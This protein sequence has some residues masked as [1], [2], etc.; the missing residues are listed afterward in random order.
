MS[1]LALPRWREQTYPALLLRHGA[2]ALAVCMLALWV[3][4]AAWSN[5]APWGDHVE[6]FG[7]AH[8][9]EWGYHKHPPLPT[10]ML[11]ATIALAGPSADWPYALAAVCGC[12]TAILTYLIARRLIGVQLAPLAILLWGLQQAFSLRAQLFNHNTVMILAVAATAL[13][14][15]RACDPDARRRHWVLAGGLA[16]LAVL[17]K[18]QALLPLGGIAAA[19]LLDRGREAPARA[20][21]LR[22]LALASGVALLVFSP[23]LLWMVRHD[24]STVRYAAQAGQVLPWSSRG[25]SVLSFLAQQL[26][27][28]AP[29]LVLALGLW[30]VMRRRSARAGQ[31]ALESSRHRRARIWLFGLVVVPL[32]GTLVVCPLFGLKLQNHWGYQSLQFVA[33]GL[34]WRLRGLP[35]PGGATLALAVSA[36][37][38]TLMIFAF[39]PRDAAAEVERR[40]DVRYP[41][42]SLAGAVRRDW[43]SATDCPLRLIVGPSFEAGLVSVYTPGWPAVLEDGDYKR[44]PWIRPEDLQRQGAVYLAHD[45]AELDRLPATLRG[46]M[47]VAARPTGEGPRVYWAVLPPAACVGGPDAVPGNE[48]DEDPLES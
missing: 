28:L 36:I 9:L 2:L 13:A 48:D 21:T 34:A 44:S 29:A 37:H 18:Y 26:R 15:L 14:V 11:A 40:V 4:F 7:W 30:L 1:Y 19:A 38:F 46:S 41:A 43:R 3:G 42:R 16:G 45:P 39:L 23:H 32:V 20:E 31:T 35:R 22:G 25:L 12:G 33:L 27:L 47:E 24:L 5:T 8:S 17:S 6:Q 10:W